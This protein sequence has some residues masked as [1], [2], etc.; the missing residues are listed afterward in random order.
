MNYVFA[1][2]IGAV[3]GAAGGYFLRSKQANAIWLAPVLSIVGAVL[4]SVL[5][6][7]L[8]DPG[9]GFK[10]VGLQIVLAAVGVGIVYALSTR[11]Q[12]SASS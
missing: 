2:V 10:E 12:A 8:G 5:A 3:I 1:I 6:T 4:A 7:M 9:Y 11:S